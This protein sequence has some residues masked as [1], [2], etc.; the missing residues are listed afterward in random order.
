[1]CAPSVAAK[2]AKASEDMKQGV[3]GVYLNNLKDIPRQM[4][5]GSGLTLPNTTG[6][7]VRDVT[8]QGVAL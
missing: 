5:L 6:A 3:E 7:F 1:M 2:V 4:Q 8:R